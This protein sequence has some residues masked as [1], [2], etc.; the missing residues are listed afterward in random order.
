MK[1]PRGR[2]VVAVL[3]L[4]ASLTL[5]APANASTPYNVNVIFFGVTHNLSGPDD[6]AIVGQNIFVGFQN[7]V[8]SQGQA[9]TTG[10]TDSTLVEMD[11]HGHIEHQVSIPGK[12]DGMGADAANNRVIVTVNEDGNSRLATVDLN[13]TMTSYTYS[14]ATLP[15]HGGTDAV[16]VFNGKIYVSASCGGCQNP[17]SAGTTPPAGS[18]AVYE[19]ALSGTTATLTSTSINVDSSA[20]DA[21]GQSTK[22]AITD[23]DSNT[24]MPS[25]TSKFGGDFMLDSQGDKFAVF[26][27]SMAPGAPLKMLKLQTSVD[28]TAVATQSQG[29]LVVTDSSADTV[30]VV[31]GPFTAGQVFTSA[32]PCNDNAAPATCPAAGFPANYLATINLANGAVTPLAHT[33]A[34]AYAKGLAFMPA[35]ASSSSDSTWAIVGGVGG[36]VVVIAAVGGLVWRRTQRKSA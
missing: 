34:T 8:D 32:T 35:A 30:E 9:S 10:A 25:S 11:V 21:S 5:G 13:G 17:A 28:D 12:I 7:G 16:S 18:P 26:A 19:V 2:A 1:F 33:G 24:V 14:P 6:I 31:S 22:L 20:S 27:A 3:G 23:A 15:H 29:V 36:G 4:A